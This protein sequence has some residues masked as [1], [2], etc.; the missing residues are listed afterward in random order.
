MNRHK[1][2]V[3]SALDSRDAQLIIKVRPEGTQFPY[4]AFHAEQR[5]SIVDVSAFN[6]FFPLEEH[7][8]QLQDSSTD[9]PVEP[10][11]CFIISEALLIVPSTC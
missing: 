2:L 10:R 8:S 9:N 11:Q 3:A 7:L 5:K 4:R 1:P 6:R